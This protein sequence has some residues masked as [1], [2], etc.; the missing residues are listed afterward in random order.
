MEHHLAQFNAARLRRRLDHVDTAEF[1]AALD[2]VNALAEVS[3]GFVWRLTD[4]EGRS[5]SY[6]PVAGVD[7]PLEIVNLSVWRDLDALRH[8]VFRSGHVAYLRRRREWFEPTDGPA[9]VCWWM[10]AG[11]VPDVDDAHRRLAAVRA[12]GPSDAGW[13]LNQPRRAP[14]AP[15]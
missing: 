11:T 3:P 14:A 2:P 13:P 1:V 15:R 4:D 5:S 10:P 12:D 9:T 7:D 8:F 6:V